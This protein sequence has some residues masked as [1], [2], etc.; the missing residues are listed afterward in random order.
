[1]QDS[2]HSTIIYPVG[3]HIG[4]RNIESNDMRFI[5]QSDSLKEIT[6]MC[7]CPHKRFLAVCEKHYGNN[8]SAYIAFYDMKN[9]QFRNDKTYINV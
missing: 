2:N 9:V 8:L 5:K 7:F 3:K 1:M 6:A 4:V